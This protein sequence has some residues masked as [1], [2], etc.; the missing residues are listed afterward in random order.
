MYLAG[1]RAERGEG[2][3]RG[4]CEIVMG[5]LA[6][7]WNIWLLGAASNICGDT[8]SPPGLILQLMVMR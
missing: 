4:Y 2:G 3:V 6:R 7:T 5:T 8:V 1:N